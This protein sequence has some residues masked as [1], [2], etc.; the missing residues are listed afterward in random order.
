[1]TNNVEINIKIIPIEK[2]KDIKVNKIKDEKLKALSNNIYRDHKRESLKGVAFLTQGT[3]CEL[4][5]TFKKFDISGKPGNRY[6]NKYN[7]N[8]RRVR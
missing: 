6:K 4:P 5:S 7:K 2:T 3:I 1:M 8:K